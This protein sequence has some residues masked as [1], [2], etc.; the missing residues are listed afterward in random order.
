MPI[1]LLSLPFD[2]LEY[3]IDSMDVR[4]LIALSL[5]SKQAKNL[6]QNSNREIQCLS[7]KV[8]KNLIRLTVYELP[9]EKEYDFVLRDD[10]TIKVHLRKKVKVWRKE[11]FTQSDWMAHFLSLSEDSMVSMVEIHNVD[12]ITYLDTVKQ[13]IPKCEILEITAN[14]SN[15]TTKMA[16]MKLS[17]IAEE[18]VEVARNPS[19]HEFR[20]SEYLTLNLRGVIFKDY[21][22]VFELKLEDLLM[23]NVAYITV[24]EAKITDKELNRF[25]KLWMKGNHTFYRPEYIKLCTEKRINREEV[26]KGFEYAR[27]NSRLQLERADGKKLFI[28]I[29]GR[30]AIFE[31]RG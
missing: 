26:F 13:M 10:S 14:C 22:N 17:S 5:C 9:S 21:N 28:W 30:D 15:E 7:A 2:D 4:A 8:Y 27:V 18:K 24:R 23:A 11:G 1:R 31:F 25:L 12:S 20:I 16:F 6:V 19:N 3:V 29:L